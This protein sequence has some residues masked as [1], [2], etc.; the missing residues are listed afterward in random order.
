MCNKFARSLM[1]TLRKVIVLT[2][3]VVSVCFIPSS[4][5]AQNCSGPGRTQ[6]LFSLEGR[7]VQASDGCLLSADVNTGA[8]AGYSFNKSAGTEYELGPIVNSI[9]AYNF[10]RKCLGEFGVYKENVGVSSSHPDFESEL[11]RCNSNLFG[12]EFVVKRFTVPLAGVSPA[13]LSF[14]NTAQL[15]GCYV[16]LEF[17]V[18]SG[19]AHAVGLSSATSNGDDYSLTINDGNFPD[20][21]QS[22]SGKHKDQLSEVNG[23]EYKKLMGISGKLITLR[24]MIF[25]CPVTYADLI[26]GSEYYQGHDKAN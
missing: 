12:Q 17:N 23:D 4:V 8:D 26:I 10:L 13:M 14:A 22:L 24:G 2:A 11:A 3:T 25:K 1:G 9:D 5:F 16:M 19:D 18:S 6:P 20:E 7:V 15:L 21:S